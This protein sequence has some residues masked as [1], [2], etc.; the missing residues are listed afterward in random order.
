MIG[1]NTHKKT[2]TQVGVFF[3]EEFWKN[4]VRDALKSKESLEAYFQTSFPSIPYPIFIPQNFAHKIKKAGLTSVLAKQ[5]LPHEAELHT[6]GLKD[7]IGDEIHMKAAGVIH[8]YENRVLFMPTQICPVICRYCFRKNEL[9][10]NLDSFKQELELTLH[11]LKSH[12]EVN[13]IIFSGGDPLMLS[14]EKLS[15]YLQ[16]FS[17]LPQIQFIRFHTR[18]PTILPSRITN[19]FIKTIKTYENHF[20]KII[21]VIHV[22]HTEEID[23]EVKKAF[24]LLG[25]NFMTLTQTVLLKEINNDVNTLIELFHQLIEF[26]IRPYYLHHPDPVRGGTHFM[27]SLEEGRKI[28]RELR[29]KLSGWM[30]PEY[31]LDI[32]EG[33]GKVPAFNPEKIEFS[34]ELT[35]LWGE[36]TNYLY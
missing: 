10:Q 15:G 28:Y 22:N 16:A 19:E 36:K 29:I 35:G 24:L 1:E 9:N 30:L 3:E 23:E 20:K 12:P 17:S 32:P 34:H 33:K 11:Y 18:M 4:E 8:R 21:F 31:I 26:N 14:N 5:F 6:M 7:P 2:P 13:E 25:Q 27:I